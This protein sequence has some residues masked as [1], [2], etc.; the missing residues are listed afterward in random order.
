M[1]GVKATGELEFIGGHVALD[2]ANTAE[3]RDE[4]VADESLHS[5]GD[6]RVWGQRYGL[7]SRSVPGADENTEEL[8]RAIQAREL[9]YRLFAARAQERGLQ[10]RDLRRLSELAAE[11]YGAGEL[12]ADD[13]GRA[14]W[15]WS[16]RA[17]SSVR[18]TVVHEAIGLLAALPAGRLKQCPGDHCGWLFLDTTKRGNRRWCSMVQCGQEAKVA[19]RRMRQS[20][21]GLFFPD[22]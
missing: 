20:G 12:T 5:P 16:P 17:L 10:A 18:H 3:A 6:L 19:R 15:R 4:A 8:E 1:I 13:A 2:F 9:I 22:E 14:V 7:L 11:A 21:A